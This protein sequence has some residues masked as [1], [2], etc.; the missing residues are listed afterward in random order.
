MGYDLRAV[1]GGFNSKGS[2]WQTYHWNQST[3][4]AKGGVSVSVRVKKEDVRT[5]R[6]GILDVSHF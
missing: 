4:D 1:T 2:G 3:R 5:S 6:P